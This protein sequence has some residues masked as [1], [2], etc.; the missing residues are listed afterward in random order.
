MAPEPLTNW[1]RRHVSW[2][3]LNPVLYL[4]VVGRGQ[5]QKKGQARLF[6]LR[7]TQPW[8]KRPD[9]ALVGSSPGPPI[10]ARR[11]QSGLKRPISFPLQCCARLLAPNSFS[12]NQ[13]ASRILSKIRPA[14]SSIT[15]FPTRG[16]FSLVSHDQRPTS[17]SRAAISCHDLP[18]AARLHLQNILPAFPSSK[19]NHNHPPTAHRQTPQPCR[20]ATFPSIAGPSS[21][22]R[23]HSSPRSC[24]V[25][26]RSSRSR[27]ESRSARR[28][29][30]S[31]A[32]S[33]P[34]PTAPVPRSAPPPTATMRTRP[35]NPRYVCF[36]CLSTAIV[37]VRLPPSRLALIAALPLCEF[38][39]TS[40][41]AACFDRP[42]PYFGPAGKGTCEPYDG[43]HDEQ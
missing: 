16:C 11:S 18:A 33:V 36:P 41:P 40:Y 10:D 25:V 20:N 38:P 4:H 24:A 34:V 12:E 15:A 43:C 3:V 37:G 13:A 28:T 23:I 35:Q 2:S 5:R 27:S 9:S 39:P 31:A 29:W 30:P 26:A 19:H 8:G 32:V 14:L 7:Q 17:V 22:P 6:G 21:R 1:A 42:G